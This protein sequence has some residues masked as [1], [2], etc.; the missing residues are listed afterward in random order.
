MHNIRC[1]SFH[2]IS[3]SVNLCMIL[4][5]LGAFSQKFYLRHHDSLLADQLNYIARLSVIKIA[6]QNPTQN[7]QLKC[8]LN[9]SKQNEKSVF[10]QHRA[11]SILE[12]IQHNTSANVLCCTLYTRHHDQSDSL[13]LSYKLT[14]ILYLFDLKFIVRAQFLKVKFIIIKFHVDTS[15]YTP[16]LLELN[17]EFVDKIGHDE[18]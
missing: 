12:L 11:Q 7:Y 3:V 6:L 5:A 18:G 17:K 4:N 8:L 10:E 9:A 2:T 1:H 13:C 14:P 15:S 16:G